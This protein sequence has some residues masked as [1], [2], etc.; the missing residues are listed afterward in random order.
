MDNLLS[1]SLGVQDGLNFKLLAY[2][3]G[4]AGIIVEW[5][6]YSLH[7]SLAFRRWSAFGALLWASQYFLLNAWTAGLTMGFTALRTLVSGRLAKSYYRH[8]AV[9]GF[10]GLFSG[11][12]WLSWQGIISLLPAFA[13]INTT[14][15]LFYLSN[16]KMR[17]ALL[18]SSCAWAANDYYWQAWPSLLAETVAM[19]INL[20]TIRQLFKLNNV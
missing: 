2:L 5:R 15:A 12:T 8:L 16:R 7:C 10:I 3:V 6:A 4:S 1:F 17:M 18:L 14:L 13:V 11:L 20:N 19:F 9:C